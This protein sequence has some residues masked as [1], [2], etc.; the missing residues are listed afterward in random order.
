V[1]SYKS[2]LIIVSSTVT[3]NNAGVRGAGL[4]VH[5]G[6]VTLKRSMVAGNGVSSTLT[7]REITVSGG[8][9]TADDYNLFGHDGV[10]GVAGFT[11][12]SIDLVPNDP[13]G[14]IVLPLADNGGGTQT[15]ALAIGSPALDASPDIV[16]G[17]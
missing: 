4:F 5:G 9:V 13:I 2:E 10:A 3:G 17:D 15:H 16:S 11:L 1:D 8:A 12:G 14:G 7:G 6:T